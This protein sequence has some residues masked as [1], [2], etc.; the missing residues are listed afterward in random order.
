MG[1]S[2]IRWAPCSSPRPA[3]RAPA[4]AHAG[5]WRA[6]PPP[7]A[8]APGGSYTLGPLRSVVGEEVYTASVARA[9]GYIAAGD[10][11]QVNLTHPLRAPVTGDTRALAAD[12]IERTGAWFGA[13]LETPTRTIV[14]TSPE[15]LVRVTPE[16]RISARPVKGTR[17]PGGERELAA[18]EKDAAELAMIVDLMRNDLGRVCEL[19]SVRVESAREIEAHARV[20]HTVATVSGQLRAEA[21]WEDVLR[22]VFPAGSITGAPKIRAMQII[23]ELEPEPRG[24]YCGSIV[25]IGDDGSMDLSV[26]IRTAEIR[27]GELRYGVGAGIVADSDPRGEWRETLQKA[28]G[29]ARSV[30]STVEG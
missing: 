30:G 11:Y 25:W 29:F 15:L 10:V 17:P 6:A 9:L 4:G 22:A 1:V 20:A 28:E 23:D 7:A 8:G 24:V 2:T 14:S 3:A 16:G 18:S 26:A 21:S 19:G 13:Y 27:A 12:A 5:P